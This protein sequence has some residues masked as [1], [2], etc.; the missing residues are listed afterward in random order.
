[1]MKTLLKISGI[2]KAFP[3]VQALKN[4]CLNVYVGRAMALMGEKGR[5]NPP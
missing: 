3:G 4:A 2:D 5:V 1:M